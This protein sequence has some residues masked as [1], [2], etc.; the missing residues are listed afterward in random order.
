[1]KRIWNALRYGD[2][3]TRGSIGSVIIFCVLAVVLFIVCFVTGRP[4]FIA[5]GLMSGVIAL[6]ISQTFTLVDEDYV[7]QSGLGGSKQMVRSAG[8]KK[9][10]LSITRMGEKKE[11]PAQF[12]QYDAA[13]LKKIKRKNR[14]RKDHRP[15]LI[16][17]SKSF[18]I[19]ECPAF[20]WRVHNKVYLLL[21]EKEPRKICIS[22]ELIRHMDYEPGVPVDR[23][24]DY[25][26]FRK[27]NLVTSV[28]REFLPDCYEH[29]RERGGIRYK[30]L[31]TIYP[32]IRVTNRSAATV[33]DLL[34]LNFMPEDKITVSDKLNGYFKRI[35]AAQILYRDKVYSITEYKDAIE[36]ELREMCYAEMPKRE[37]DI[38]LENL[39]KGRMISGQYADHYSDLRER[40]RARS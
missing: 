2:A 33:L 30:N 37:F 1:M 28:F 29:G 23:E 12:D 24:K 18:G 17:S 31:Y 32:D 26:A 4:L 38:T 19:R 8:A 5:L 35:Y 7:A 9:K 20:I 25:A 39:V 6:L 16:D 14:V 15:I 10:D 11:V 27:E 40:I 13:Q 36:K 21:L 3:A 22:R 34:C